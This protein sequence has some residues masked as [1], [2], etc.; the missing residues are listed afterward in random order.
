MGKKKASVAVAVPQTRWSRFQTAVK[1]WTESRRKSIAA[2]EKIVELRS[3][4]S[5]VTTAQVVI[6]VGSAVSSSRLSVQVETELYGHLK[7]LENHQNIM[8][9]SLQTMGILAKQGDSSSSD[10]NGND[11]DAMRTQAKLAAPSEGIEEATSATEPK[12]VAT[13]WPVDDEFT[14]KLISDM[15]QQSLLEISVYEMLLDELQGQGSSSSSKLDHDAIVTCVA[16]FT[17]PPYVNLETIE[18]VNSIRE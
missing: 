13:T 2:V 10:A 6:G 5:Y 15:Q 17:F 4:A 3:Q 16:C 8:L 14:M 12:A 1:E 18:S 9:Q 7:I 11:S